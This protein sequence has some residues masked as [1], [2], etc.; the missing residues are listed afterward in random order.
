VPNYWCTELGLNASGAAFAWLATLL[1]PPGAQPIFAACEAAARQAE[2]GAGGLTF[3]PYIADGERFNPALRGGFCGLSLRHD[4]G[5]LA[6][7]VLEGVAFAIREHIEIMTEAGAP[8]QEIHVSG[9]GARVELWNQIKADVSG[10]PVVSV[11]SDATSLGVAILA[12]TA[13]NLHSSLEAAVERSV[14][15]SQRYEPDSRLADLYA[16]R[17]ARFRSLAQATAETT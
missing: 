10:V 3:L 1:A 8:T 7:A 4:R 12:A 11:A 5:A 2:P 6:R 15:L 9:G 16:E 14:K 17:Y 13:V